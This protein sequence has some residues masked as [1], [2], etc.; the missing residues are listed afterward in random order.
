MFFQ[1]LE[2]GFWVAKGGLLLMSPRILRSFT[3]SAA[4]IAASSVQAKLVAGRAVAR[5]TR[6][7]P[8]LIDRG[9]KG[10]WRV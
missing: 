7:L 4:K 2:I 9:L 6:G 5:F 8:L 10:V 1:N 3:T